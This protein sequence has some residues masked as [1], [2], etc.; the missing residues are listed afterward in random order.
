MKSFLRLAFSEPK[1]RKSMLWATTGTFLF[2]LFDVIPE[3][4]LGLMI[5]VAIRQ[6]Q[7]FLF[8]YHFA[9]NRSSVFILGALALLTWL[10]GI[11]FQFLSSMQWKHAASS[12][13]FQLRMQLCHYILTHQKKQAHST[14]KAVTLRD[15][16]RGTNRSIEMVEFFISYTLE[17]FFKLFF[18]ALIVTPIL[19][20]IAPVFLFYALSICK[21]KDAIYVQ[22]N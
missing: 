10:L 16:D 13:Q 8:Q 5:D 21:K 22:R 15:D 12:V 6:E 19:F 2:K 9:A 14:A 3:I 7:S 20:I 11:L 17:D 18:A 1:F 4:I